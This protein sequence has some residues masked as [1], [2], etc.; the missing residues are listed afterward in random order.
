MRIIH[1]NVEL[2]ITSNS[3][4]AYDTEV[5]CSVRGS[6]KTVLSLHTEK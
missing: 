3:G 1:R 2:V 6:P 4:A 5:R